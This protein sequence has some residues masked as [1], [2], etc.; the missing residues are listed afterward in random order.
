MIE[1]PL[2]PTPDPPPLADLLGLEGRVALI[3]GAAGAIGRALAERFAEAGAALLVTDATLPDAEMTATVAAHRYGGAALAATLD[4]HDPAAALAVAEQARTELGGLDVVVH[5]G[6]LEAAY[7]A[8]E[9]VGRAM[10]S[11]VV[12]NVDL[13]D[14]RSDDLV[15]ALNLGLAP[16][17]VRVIKIA[18]DPLAAADGIARIALLLA[19]EAAGGVTGITIP[20]SGTPS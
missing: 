4:M 10:T 17:A 3:T 20:V 19:S 5:V 18:P 8:V 9:A 15:H 1:T 2:H 6:S 14:T 12:I 7:A 16:R 11:G 13:R